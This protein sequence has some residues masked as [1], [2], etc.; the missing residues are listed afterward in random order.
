MTGPISTDHFTRAE[1]LRRL[2]QNQAIPF[3]VLSC[4]ARTA[5]QRGDGLVIDHRRSGRCIGACLHC[6]QAR[7]RVERRRRSRA[8]SCR[9]RAGRNRDV[10]VV[11]PIPP[12]R[13]AGDRGHLTPHIRRRSCAVR[14]RGRGAP[15]GLPLWQPGGN[16]RAA[17]G[18]GRSSRRVTATRRPPRSP[19]S[20]SSPHGDGRSH[21]PPPH[22]PRRDG[23]RRVQ[24]PRP[25]PRLSGIQPPEPTWKR[26]TTRR[27]P[28]RSRGTSWGI[29][30]EKA[31]R[32]RKPIPR[33]SA[34]AVCTKRFRHARGACRV[35]VFELCRYSPG[36]DVY[37]TLSGSAPLPAAYATSDGWAA[38]ASPEAATTSCTKRSF[39]TTAGASTNG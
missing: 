23:R 19:L 6:P 30:L 15:S 3:R 38:V 28:L 11:F 14:R 35:S 18:C 20:P 8:V 36:P 13:R 24:P 16:G 1:R 29:L 25:P 37:R 33:E 26:P 27:T 2:A 10:V 4:I 17:A 7:P 32:P 31:G 39:A 9:G 12:P 5:G 22:R 21:I 34:L